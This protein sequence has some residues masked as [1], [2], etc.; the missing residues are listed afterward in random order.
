VAARTQL[1]ELQSLDDPLLSFR[2]VV[3]ENFAG[4]PKKYVEKVDLPFNNLDVRE[5]VYNGSS[6]TYFPGTHNVSAFGVTFYED[7][8]ATVTQWIQQWKN[9]IKDFSTGL[10]AL[11][12]D[13]KKILDVHL[14][15]TVGD[16]IMIAHLEGIFPTST[17]NFSLTYEAAARISVE[18]Q[19]SC[20]NCKLEFIKQGKATFG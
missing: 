6:F 19:F 11:P 8:K 14:L 10:Y 1:A 9:A 16:T 18:Q 13:Y 15:D 20:D 4:L 12:K 17:S 3:Q 7:D 5:G 2:W